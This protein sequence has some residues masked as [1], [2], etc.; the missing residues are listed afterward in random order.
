[1]N[2]IPSATSGTQ[3]SMSSYEQKVWDSL[4]E[5]WGA[6]SNR[7]GMPAWATGALG[8]AGDATGAAAKKVGEATP[9]ALKA[10][11]QMSGSTTSLTGPTSGFPG[12]C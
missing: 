7:R 11:L 12:D 9:E 6:K 8:K 2:E 1:M 10:P 4:N 3:G 5:H